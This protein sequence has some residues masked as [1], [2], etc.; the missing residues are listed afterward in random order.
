M[1]SVAT[2]TN[3]SVKM[4][5]VAMNQLD[6]DRQVVVRVTENNVADATNVVILGDQ[7]DAM[8]RSFA[9]APTANTTIAVDQYTRSSLIEYYKHL[10]MSR[11]SMKDLMLSTSDTENLK[12]SLIYQKYIMDGQKNFV[13]KNLAPLRVNVGSGYSDTVDIPNWTLVKDENTQLIISKLKRNTSVTLT[14]TIDAVADAANFVP[15]GNA[16]L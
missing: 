8:V 1:S 14:F 4:S 9:A 12:G 16:S 6:G 10:C 3:G 11:F 13:T 2:S 15:V 7:I 5:V